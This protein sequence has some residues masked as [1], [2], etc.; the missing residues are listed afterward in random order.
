MTRSGRDRLQTR[1]RRQRAE[2]SLRLH[3]PPALR[4]APAIGPKDYRLPETQGQEAPA[5]SALTLAAPLTSTGSQP[6]DATPLT[7]ILHA[8]PGE[9]FLEPSVL[10]FNGLH[11]GDHRRVHPAELRQPLIERRIAHAT[12]AAQLCRRNTAPAWRRIERINGSPYLLVFIRNL[13]RH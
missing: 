11:L 8:Q 12:F 5:A 7:F 3:H 2:P 6:A 4:S 1:P 9:H 10:V 13:L